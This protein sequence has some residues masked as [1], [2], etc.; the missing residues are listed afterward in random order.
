MAKKDINI[1]VGAVNKARDVLKGVGR[2][3]GRIKRIAAATTRAIGSVLKRVAIVGIAAFG[4]L[5]AAVKKAF[6]FEA[7][8]LQFKILLGN[9][10]R[11]RDRFNELKRLS[12]ETPFQLENIIKASRALAVFTENVLGGEKSLRLVGDAA[13]A[14]GQNIEEVAFWVGRAYS[15]LQS[16]RP[17]GEAAM[18]LQEMGVL[19]AKGRN[20]IE[21][22]QKAGVNFQGT[23][24]RVQ[25]E[26]GRFQGGM[27]ELSQTGKGLFS[28][29]KDNWTLTLATFGDQL[30]KTAKDGIKGLI[31]AL[32]ELRRSGTIEQ[33]GKRVNK[34]LQQT[35]DIV[36]AIAKGTGDER[37]AIIRNIGAQFAEGAL[38]ILE[39]AAPVIG[40]I[41]AQ[42]FKHSIAF[43]IKAAPAIA[44][45]APE[46]AAALQRGLFTGVTGREEIG[47]AAETATRLFIAKQIGIPKLLETLI[48]EV[49]KLR[50]VE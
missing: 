5:A 15:M 31:A 21:K 12:A 7:Y 43:G 1:I 19:T 10:E 6:D 47:R 27:Q 48:D 49:K 2:T 39:A 46:R 8:R 40:R 44:R 50:N 28:T 32:Q 18:R 3:L 14:V 22:M 33:W 41:M 42:A 26:L 11:A 23:W 25:Q 16:G 34:I 4:I 24:A 38:D 30:L 35:A 29:L 36:Q 37:A 13:A 20:E 9:M 45:E 17:F